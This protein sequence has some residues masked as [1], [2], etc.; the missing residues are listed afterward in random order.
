MN[1]VDSN[2]NVLMDLLAQIDLYWGAVVG[3]LNSLTVAQ[4]EA[5]GILYDNVY[6]V[7]SAIE[8]VML[9]S[10]DPS[11]ANRWRPSRSI[12]LFLV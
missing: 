2:A 7:F 3:S 6:Q 9:I 8:A 4:R 11:V 10:H 5:R 1:E 12:Q